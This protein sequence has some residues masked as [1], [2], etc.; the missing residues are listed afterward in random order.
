MGLRSSSLVQRITQFNR[1]SR[2]AKDLFKKPDLRGIIKY[3]VCVIVTQFNAS[4]NCFNHELNVKLYHTKISIY[5]IF[6]A[7]DQIKYTAKNQ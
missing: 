1:I 3:A 6:S 4:S 2:Q 7:N 5:Q